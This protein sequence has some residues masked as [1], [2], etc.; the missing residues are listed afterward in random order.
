MNSCSIYF[1]YTRQMNEGTNT[2]KNDRA[3]KLFSS[4]HSSVNFE[5]KLCCIG[6]VTCCPKAKAIK[7]DEVLIKDM[8]TGL[9]F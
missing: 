7:N 9:N 5:L 8:S 1:L 2:Y 3:Y 6:V 4:K